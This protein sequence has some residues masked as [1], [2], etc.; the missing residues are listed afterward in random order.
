M[1]SFIS[2]V[3]YSSVERD[4]MRQAVALF[5]QP[6]TRDELGIGSIR[7]VIANDLFPGTSTIQTRLSYALF[8]PWIYRD[9]EGNHRITTANVERWAK[10]EELK[11]VDQLSENEKGPG[12]IG[13]R[14]RANLQRLPSEVYWL[15]LRQWGIFREDCYQDAYHRDWDRVRA[16]QLKQR[17]ADDRGVLVDGVATWH[18]ELPSAPEGFPK[19][20]GFALRAK[21][22]TFL[23]ERILDTCEGA[24]LAHAIKPHVPRPELDVDAPWD[25]FKR[26]PGELGA[27]VELAR[28][29]SALMQGAAIVY[30]LALARLGDAHGAMA[31]KHEDA[32][33]GWSER[34]QSADVARWDLQELWTFC[35]DQDTIVSPRTRGFIEDWQKL[36]LPKDYTA[37]GASKEAHQLVEERESQLKGNRSRFRNEE[38]RKNW[39]G[40]SGTSA[41]TYRWP[42]ARGFLKDLYAGLDQGNQ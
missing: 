42:T 13:R 24:L 25:A 22:A 18:P 10:D 6:E 39:G 14:S 34:A 35:A 31:K 3:D 9:L 41:M 12:V 36:L 7:D 37:I 23:Q 17:V 11:L 1:V 5:T 8:V 16:R 4:R 26:L 38:A 28:R 40:D 33:A 32:L 29:F 19:T 21:D 20:A 27:T 15:A 2:W 30:N